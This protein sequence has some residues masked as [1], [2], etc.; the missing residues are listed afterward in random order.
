[1]KYD[2]NALPGLKPL[3]FFYNIFSNLAMVILLPK[4]LVKSLSYPP[5]NNCF[6]N[7]EPITGKKKTGFTRDL[8][9][10]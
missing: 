10:A 2:P 4:L 6:Q 9:L 1:M 8:D 5:S 3:G 7:D